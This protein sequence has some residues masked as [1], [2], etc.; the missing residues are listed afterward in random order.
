MMTLL[1]GL[2][3]ELYECGPLRFMKNDMKC[4]EAFFTN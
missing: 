4:A 2:Q 1:A 3:D